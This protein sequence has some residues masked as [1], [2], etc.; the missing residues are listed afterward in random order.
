MECIKLQIYPLVRLLFIILILKFA[1]R[2]LINLDNFPLL[3]LF[4]REG[5]TSY[6]YL[7]LHGFFYIAL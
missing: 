3:C 1:L 6:I 4:V 5:E 2:T 7:T